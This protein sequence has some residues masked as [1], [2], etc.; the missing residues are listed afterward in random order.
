MLRQDALV[1]PTLVQVLPA[2]VGRAVRSASP[3]PFPARRRVQQRW[4]Y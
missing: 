1:D 4:N 3:A 2:V